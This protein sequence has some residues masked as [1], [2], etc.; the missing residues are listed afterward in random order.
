[1]MRRKYFVRFLLSGLIV[2]LVMGSI[3]YSEAQGTTDGTMAGTVLDT[4]GAVVGAARVNAR[5]NAT[6][7]AFV[8][9]SG[10][11]GAFRINNVPVGIYTVTIEA[12]GFKRYSNP[13]VEVQLN[14]VTDVNAVLEPGAVTETVTVTGAAAAELIETTTSQLGKSFEERK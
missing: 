6:A 12:Q 5:N 11:N 7:Q 4:N 2:A 8:S 10:D 1:M 14:R 9:Q 13:N 3:R